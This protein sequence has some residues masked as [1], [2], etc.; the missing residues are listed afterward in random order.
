MQKGS[1]GGKGKGSRPQG[2]GSRP[3]GKGARSQ[4]SR[5]QGMG[6]RS[7]SSSRSN[8]GSSQGKGSRSPQGMGSR[9]NSRNRSNNRSSQGKGKGLR[10]K[11]KGS[12]QQGTRRR[13]RE[14]EMNVDNYFNIRLDD[15]TTQPI[16]RPFMVDEHN[17]RISSDGTILGPDRS[18]GLFDELGYFFILPNGEKILPNGRLIGR[19]TF[20]DYE[21]VTTIYYQGQYKLARNKRIIGTMDML[22]LRFPA[23]EYGLEH[24]GVF[25]EPPPAH[26]VRHNWS[27]PSDRQ[28][29]SAH[30]GFG[31]TPPAV[32]Q[33]TSKNVHRAWGAPPSGVVHP[34]RTFG[35][36]PFVPREYAPI[37]AAAV[38]AVWG[39]GLPPINNEL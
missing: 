20:S 35:F 9:T 28:Q 38:D 27:A 37:G 6:N 2:K 16:K 18:D 15:G 3:Q 32:R 29:S 19:A 4:G 10:V 23:I 39:R 22:D 24:V 8:N 31:F 30:Y 14:N 36:S 25:Y 33:V 26:V 11:G 5:V 34:A 13:N 17:N 12:R 21:P 7:R 1:Q